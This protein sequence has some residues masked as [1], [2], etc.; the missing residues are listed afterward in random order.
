MSI[1]RK[2]ITT[3]LVALAAA[4]TPLLA[5]PAQAASAQTSGPLAAQPLN[6]AA[7][8]DS[9]ASGQGDK[10]SGWL[11]DYCYLS[12]LAAPQQAEALLN[13]VRPATFTTSACNGSVIEDPTDGYAESAL[14]GTNG[15]NGQPLNN[16]QLSYIDPT[17][18]DP[19]D[20]L[21]IS[22]GGNDI[23]FANIVT[24]CVDAFDNCTTDP[25]VT[26]IQGYGTVQSALQRLGP[27][28]TDSSGAPT[29]RL[30]DLVKAVNARQDID[31][32]F[33]TAY[34]DPTIAPDGSTCGWGGTYPGFGGFDA[35]TQPKAEWASAEVIAP[36]NAA[37]ASTVILA[38]EQPEPH[39][40]WH[41]VDLSG[42]FENYGFCAHNRYVNTIADSVLEQGDQN[43]AM[44]PNNAGQQ[45]LA[46]DIF[47]DYIS[48]PLMSASVSA[49]SSLIVQSS[50]NL[51]VQTLNFDNGPI[52]NA[53]V[54]V[55]GSFVGYTNKAGN[56]TF[57]DTF[58]TTG[59]HTIVARANGYPDAQA[60]VSV[61][62]RPYVAASNPEP[63]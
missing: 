27:Y 15:P 55:D 28:P 41:F 38:N 25:N 20:A 1:Y 52:P 43:G 59:D 63:I 62:T 33:L 48:L 6:I 12:S 16:G 60:V 23:G 54:W 51:T 11:N 32:V 61:Q 58:S 13:G 22:I 39:P 26:G 49:T 31:N 21:T 7:I 57:S 42:A 3:G 29:G 8:G 47:H 10:G 5:G 44:H 19:V 4:A 18:T 53:G 56:L 46:N 37:L 24:S 36:L 17:R 2:I 35:I 34:P 40:V 50:S 14:L 30:G 9:F 45:A